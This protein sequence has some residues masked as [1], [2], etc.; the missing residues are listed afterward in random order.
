M[1][2]AEVGGGREIRS[3]E[4]AGNNHLKMSTQIDGTVDGI[5]REENNAAPGERNEDQ[6]AANAKIMPDARCQMHDERLAISTSDRLAIGKW[7]KWA[8][9]DKWTNWQWTRNPNW[10][11]SAGSSAA[12]GTGDGAVLP[13][14]K[15]YVLYYLG[16]DDDSGI[17]GGKKERGCSK[18]TR[19]K[20][21]RERK[22]EKKLRN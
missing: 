5:E 14:K 15:V 21:K 9:I 17:T 2:N 8:K 22:K 16:R 20:R 12:M 11:L 6:N 1:I 7:A 4:D 3:N 10:S 19:S 18:K 13:K